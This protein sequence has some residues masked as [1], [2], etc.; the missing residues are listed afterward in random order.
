MKKT[1]FQLDFRFRANPLDNNQ[2]KLTHENSNNNKESIQRN[3]F[4]SAKQNLGIN[5]SV[6]P[7]N[8]KEFLDKVS[9]NC[10][11]KIRVFYIIYLV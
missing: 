2:K 7:K 3:S 1:K 6:Q 5:N 8:F 4:I 9:C 10:K 11:N